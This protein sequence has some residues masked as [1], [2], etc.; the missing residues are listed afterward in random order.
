MAKR[1]VNGGIA[2]ASVLLTIMALE[3]LARAIDFVAP[4]PAR[5][6]FEFRSRLPPPYRNVPYDV[7]ELIREDL[8]IKWRTSPDFG[9][10][11]EDRVGRY[12]NITDHRR[13]TVGGADGPRIW[14][15]GGSTVMGAEVPD[16]YTLPSVVQRAANDDGWRVR[17][18]NVGAT[19]IT[20]EHQLFRLRNM[21]PV[22]KGD[23]VVF[24]DGV[25]DVIQSLYYQNPTGNMVDEN[26][27]ALD[28]LS[29]GQRIAFAINAKLGPYS[30][31][32]RRFIDPTAPERREISLSPDLIGS[33]ERNYY[34]AI[35]AA[36][37]TAKARGAIFFHFLQPTI[38]TLEHP[39]AYEKSLIENEWLYPSNLGEVYAAGYPALRRAAVRAAEAGVISVDLSSALDR[40]SREIFLDYCHVTEPGNSILGDAIYRVLRQHRDH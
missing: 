28:R 27:K 6:W 29:F 34:D 7:Q 19:T 23:I 10:L 21:T 26:R 40:R 15:F 24:Y 36:S 8:A 17:T 4:A 33:L 37:E 3:G 31:L 11:P 12:V 38:Y 39:S 30:A 22:S 14:I 32:V 9:W 13:V 20:I 2:V 35:I 1:L 18:E 5:S 25:N 16:A